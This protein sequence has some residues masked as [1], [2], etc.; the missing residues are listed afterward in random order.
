MEPPDGTVISEEELEE[1]LEAAAGAGAPAFG[2]L[3]EA[4]AVAAGILLEEEEEELE[5]ATEARAF[6]GAMAAPAA[7]ETWRGM[8]TSG[9]LGGSEKEPG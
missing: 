7:V 5:A 6:L 8:R 4:A 1:L 3:E 9:Y 2:A